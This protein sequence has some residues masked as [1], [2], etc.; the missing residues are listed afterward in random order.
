MVMKDFGQAFNWSRLFQHV[1]QRVKTCFRFFLGCNQRLN[2]DGSSP[3]VHPPPQQQS[4]DHRHQ[5]Q[6]ANGESHGAG[7]CVILRLGNLN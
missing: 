7:L 1:S 6:V 2:L 4:H 5:E 3:M